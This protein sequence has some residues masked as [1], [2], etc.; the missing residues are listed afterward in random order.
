[1]DAMYSRDIAVGRAA[2]SQPIL[3][4]LDFGVDDRP[5]FFQSLSKCGGDIPYRRPQ[6]IRCG[7]W[8]RNP[9]LYGFLAKVGRSDRCRSPFMLGGAL[10]LC[11]A[12]IAIVGI[13]IVQSSFKEQRSALIVAAA[14]GVERFGYGD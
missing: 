2:E 8:R 10:M 6:P 12:M 4:K 13:S 14:R 7:G 1:M 9:G 5:P 3:N 11:A